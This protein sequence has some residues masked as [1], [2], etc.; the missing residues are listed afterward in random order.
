MTGSGQQGQNVLKKKEIL[1]CA[2]I[3]T[4]FKS[5]YLLFYF[6]IFFKKDSAR[7]DGR[8]ILKQLIA[9]TNVP[10]KVSI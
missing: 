2:Q 1:R 10:V 9:V 4:C 5:E 8:L 7:R 3:S 6:F